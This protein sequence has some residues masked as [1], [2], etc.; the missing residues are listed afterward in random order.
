MPSPRTAAICESVT[1]SPWKVRITPSCTPGCATFSR[2]AN[3]ESIFG[4]AKLA[5]AKSTNIAKVIKLMRPT[6][7]V[8]IL[9][10]SL[11]PVLS[12]SQ[13][14]SDRAGDVLPALGRDHGFTQP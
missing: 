2:D 1:L 14:G 13:G 6:L 5:P 9:Q 10:F 4:A 11:L 3:S 12:T 7:I 8:P